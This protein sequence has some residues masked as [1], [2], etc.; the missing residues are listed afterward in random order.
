MARPGQLPV[1]T[2]RAAPGAAP[3]PPLQEFKERHGLDACMVAPTKIIAGLGM[4]LGIRVLEVPGTTGDYRTLFHRQAG[5]RPR[6]TSAPALAWNA[7]AASRSMDSRERHGCVH[8]LQALWG[9][10]LPCAAC[11]KAEAIAGALSSGGFNF[12][13]LHVKAVDDTGH[14]FLLDQKVGRQA[15]RRSAPVVRA[16]LSLV[17]ACGPCC[18]PCL[19]ALF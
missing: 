1:H 6:V 5:S 7:D 8:V 11:R 9:R 15:G 18:S 17:P 4:S 10:C 3:S 13:F 19:K 16:P 2:P 12:G 14:D